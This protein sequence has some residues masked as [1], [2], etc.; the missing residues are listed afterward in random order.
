MAIPTTMLSMSV[1]HQFE[2]DLNTQI[3]IVLF[4][5]IPVA[6]ITISLFITRRNITN[7]GWMWYM[8]ALYTLSFYGLFIWILVHL[9]FLHGKIG[10][11]KEYLRTRMFWC[12]IISEVF[13]CNVVISDALYAMLF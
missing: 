2:K 8:Y 12:E 9:L 4:W 5:F 1:I 6:F 7:V 13:L 10:I 3:L 11:L